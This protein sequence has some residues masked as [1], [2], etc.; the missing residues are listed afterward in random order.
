MRN[1][2]EILKETFSKFYNP[3]EHLAA[4]EVIVKFEE[5]SL[6]HSIYPRN[7]NIWDQN[8]HTV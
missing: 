7:A 3:S 2:F 5:G 6:S 4:D 1:L 8:L